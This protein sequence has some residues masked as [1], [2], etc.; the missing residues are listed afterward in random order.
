MLLNL[1]FHSLHLLKNWVIGVIIIAGLL[2]TGYSL[3]PYL[4]RGAMQQT[5]KSLIELKKL[6]LA[7][8]KGHLPPMFI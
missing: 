5:H 2:I 4:I 6:K 7:E 1:L 3:F 8:E